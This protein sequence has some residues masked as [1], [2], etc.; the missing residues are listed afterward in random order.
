MFFLS[1]NLCK[2]LM[3][4]NRMIFEDN[5]YGLF[6]VTLFQRV[7]DEFKLKARDKRCAMSVLTYFL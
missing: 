1:A 6:T 3:F 2:F 5:E 4:L 7:V